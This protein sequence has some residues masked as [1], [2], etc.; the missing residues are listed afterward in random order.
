[1]ATLGEAGRAGKVY[2]DM[3][4]RFYPDSTLKRSFDAQEIAMLGRALDI[5]IRYK[6]PFEIYCEVA[7]SYAKN[8]SSP[9]PPTLIQLASERHFRM[10]LESGI[11]L[12]W[13]TTRRKT[14]GEQHQER[15]HEILNDRRYWDLQT[16]PPEELVGNPAFCELFSDNLQP[17]GIWQA[18]LVRY[19]EAAER[20]IK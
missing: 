16:V 17:F 11:A 13:E 10:L 3:V 2:R 5:A 7:F 12:M 8:V 19:L 4:T 20:K 9:Q 6:R 1:M 15:I 14:A 18:A